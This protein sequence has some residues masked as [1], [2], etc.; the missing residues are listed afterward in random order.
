MSSEGRLQAKGIQ[1]LRESF[2]KNAER[3]KSL[4]TFFSLGTKQDSIKS[5]LC[6]NRT[7]AVNSRKKTT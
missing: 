1:A 4:K 3:E 6:I 5:I 7:D 2:L